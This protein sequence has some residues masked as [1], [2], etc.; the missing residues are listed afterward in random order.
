[1]AQFRKKPV[2]IEAV[3]WLNR[4]IV[5]PPGPMWFCEAEEKRIINL[6][7]DILVVKTLEGEMKA[8]PG[9]WIIRGVKGEIYPCKP[10]IFAATYEALE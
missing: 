1:M 5:C 8:M 9:D 6:A 10:D 2:V 4:K 7:G 3:Q